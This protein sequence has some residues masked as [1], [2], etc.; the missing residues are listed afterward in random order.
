MI[1]VFFVYDLQHS[2]H[3]S[4]YMLVYA[5]LADCRFYGN[6]AVLAYL[7]FQTS[8]GAADPRFS[9]PLF[10]ACWADLVR[11]FYIQDTRWHRQSSPTTR[12]SPPN[13]IG[14]PYCVHLFVVLC[15]KPGFSGK[16]QLF[17]YHCFVATANSM[18]T[19]RTRLCHNLEFFFWGGE[20]LSHFQ[21]SIS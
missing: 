17:I 9:F 21:K 14:I 16:H 8:G 6:L 3:S 18:D 19:L 12:P 2:D 1:A 10:P 7:P 13:N 4:H 20:S 15:I 5:R 11:R